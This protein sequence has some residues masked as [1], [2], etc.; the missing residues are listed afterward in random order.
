MISTFYHFIS[1]FGFGG[2]EEGRGGSSP[3]TTRAVRQPRSPTPAS[4]NARIKK[5]EKKIEWLLSQQVSTIQTGGVGSSSSSS[6]TGKSDAQEDPEQ[7]HVFQVTTTTTT[8][9]GGGVG[10]KQEDVH[11]T[12]MLPLSP[13]LDRMGLPEE[14]PIM[15]TQSNA[16]DAFVVPDS[17]MRTTALAKGR[18]PPL[19]PFLTPSHP[20]R[21]LQHHHRVIINE[22]MISVMKRKLRSTSGIGKTLK[23]HDHIIKALKRKFRNLREMD[24]EDETTEWECE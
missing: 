20:R 2:R 6:V 5:L 8:T 22:E 12:E 13:L 9:T 18:R 1:S 7:E 24:E 17:I 19:S 11:Q 10:E 23:T 14:S 4:Q 16:S 15:E 21:P 3:T